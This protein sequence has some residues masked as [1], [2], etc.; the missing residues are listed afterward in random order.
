M[1]RPYGLLTRQ[2]LGDQF[3]AAVRMG[4]RPVVRPGQQISYADMALELV[5]EEFKT[6][7]LLLRASE[8][9]DQA[10]GD[11]DQYG[12]VAPF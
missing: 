3:A 7:R 8:L 9:A 6:R 1:E 11:V 5:L 10:R 12:D 4:G 2:E